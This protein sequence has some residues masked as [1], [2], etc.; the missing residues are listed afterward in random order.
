MKT[1]QSIKF[2]GAWRWHFIILLCNHLSHYIHVWLFKSI[3]ASNSSGYFLFAVKISFKSSYHRIQKRW[4]K[5][6]RIKHKQCRLNLAL[7]FLTCLRKK[8]MQDSHQGKWPQDW[9]LILPGNSSMPGFFQN[10]S[11]RSANKE[12]REASQALS[13]IIPVIRNN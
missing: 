1:F 5:Q 13:K 10:L 2:Q 6:Y 8:K 9:R 11:E 12:T 4:L 7:H 3:A